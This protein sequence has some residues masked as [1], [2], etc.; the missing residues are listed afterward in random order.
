MPSPLVW[1]SLMVSGVFNFVYY[2]FERCGI[3]HGQVGEHLTVDFDAGFVDEAHEAA[4]REILEAG[5][6]VDT[7]Y[8]ECAEVAFFLLTVAVS[9]GQTFLPGV[10]GDGPDIAAAAVVSAGEFEDFLSFCS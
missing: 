5:S 4:V 2:C 9:V 3:V 10:F 8:P 1:A 6:G 7:L